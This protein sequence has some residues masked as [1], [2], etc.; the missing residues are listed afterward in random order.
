MSKSD[1]QESESAEEQQQSAD[2][3][4][5]K[6]SNEDGDYD[7][8][9]R[10][11]RMKYYGGLGK[12]SNYQNEKIEALFQRLRLM[13]HLGFEKRTQLLNQLEAN[14]NAKLKNNMLSK[15]SRIDR[16]RFMG[17]IGK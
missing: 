15:K 5:N 8:V 14:E 2:Q 6:I 11:D 13:N 1:V 7:T 16:L 12:R 10:L 9:K 4:G 3:D 17:N